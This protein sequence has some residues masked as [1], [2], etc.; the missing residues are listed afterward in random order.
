MAN[1]LVITFTIAMGEIWLQRQ[2]SL[3]S[4]AIPILTTL[5]DR[6]KEVIESAL[7]ESR[8]RVAGPSGAAVIGPFV[9][10]SCESRR[11]P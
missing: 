2:S 7:T 4:R 5:A 10:P 8:G 6:E 9:P 3:P 1:K 11:S